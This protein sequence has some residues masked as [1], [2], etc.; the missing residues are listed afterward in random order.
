MNAEVFADW[1][2]IQ[3]HR[4]IKTA[5]SYWFDQGPRAFQAF[6]YHHLINP[7]ERELVSIRKPRFFRFKPEAKSTSEGQFAS[8]W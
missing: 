8:V 7:G 1:L 5:N 2:A 6:P 4:V 3:G